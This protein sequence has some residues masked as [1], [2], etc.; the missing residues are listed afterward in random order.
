VEQAF[1]LIMSAG[2]VA[3]DQD[4]EGDG[5]AGDGGVEGGE[6]GPS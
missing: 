1:K 2:I 4:G 6:P 3:P 5:T